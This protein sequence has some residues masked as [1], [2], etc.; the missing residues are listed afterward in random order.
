MVQESA[1]AHRDG[2]VDR[3]LEPEVGEE[4]EGREFFWE[5]DNEDTSLDIEYRIDNEGRGARGY[6]D[7][8]L[9]KSESRRKPLVQ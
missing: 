4:R 7:P 5:A 6:V 9:P 1:T 2:E 3:I 8:E